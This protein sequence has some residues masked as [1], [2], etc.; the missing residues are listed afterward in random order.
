MDR[1]SP[2]GLQ[3]TLLGLLTGALLVGAGWEAQAQNAPQNTLQNTQAAPARPASPVNSVPGKAAGRLPV[4]PLTAQENAALQA[5]FTK[6]RPATLRIEQCPVNAC[7]EPGGVGTGFL[8]SE[9]GLALTAYHVVFQ[10]SAL[11]ARTSNGKRYPVTVV[12]YD[13]QYDLAVVQVGVPKGTPFLPL[14]KAAPKVGDAALAIGNGGGAYL[15]PKFGRLTGLQSEAGRA[16]FPPGT[17]ELSAPLVPGDSGGPIINR[18]GEVAGVVSYVSV[19]GEDENSLDIH[20]YAV[21]VTATDARVAE[22][23]RGVKRDAPVIGISLEGEWS[24][25]ANLP[26]SAFVESKLGKTAG[27]FFTRV[28]PG[29]PAAKAGLQPLRFSAKGDL[30]GGDIVTAVN[31]RRIYNFSDFQYAVRRHAP[32]ETVTLSVLRGGKSISVKLTLA[33]RSTM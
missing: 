3:A 33:A 27:A 28:L 24:L 22:L 7:T 17:L 11:S 26:E 8:I 29:S 20:A 1:M 32:G 14:A 5:L 19:R 23:R 21:P 30:L 10:A 6:L 9:G 12:G 31:G 15:R 13:D 4:K 25:L 18:A 16:D 2:T